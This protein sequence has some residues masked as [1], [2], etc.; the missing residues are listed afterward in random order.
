MATKGVISPQRLGFLFRAN[1]VILLILIYHI[2]M[3]V[4]P[5]YTDMSDSAAYSSNVFGSPMV[6]SLVRLLCILTLLG[7]I[8]GSYFNRWDVFLGLLFFNVLILV[9]SL[10]DDLNALKDVNIGP[11]DYT[12]VYTDQ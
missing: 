6:Q 5:F 7:C 8:T 2:V 4:L 3:L 9:F 1:L 10:G 12:P 11:V